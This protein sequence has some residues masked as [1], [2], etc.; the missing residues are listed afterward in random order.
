MP[1]NAYAWLLES[2]ISEFPNIELLRIGEVAIE[3]DCAPNRL[4]VVDLPLNSVMLRLPVH[5][6]VMQLHHR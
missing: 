4:A 1:S 6:L 5:R 2:R 3:L